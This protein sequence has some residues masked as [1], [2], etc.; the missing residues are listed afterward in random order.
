MEAEGEIITWEKSGAVCS[1]WHQ[2]TVTISFLRVNAP[3]VITLFPIPK[4]SKCLN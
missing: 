1:K 2:T 4:I 3:D